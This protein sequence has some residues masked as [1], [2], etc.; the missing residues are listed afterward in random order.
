MV[1]VMIQNGGAERSMEYDTVSD[2]YADYVEAEV[3]PRAEKEANVKLARR[4]PKAGWLSA[5]VRRGRV[6]YNGLVQTRALPSRTDILGDIRR[7]AARTRRSSRGM[8]I[9]GTFHSR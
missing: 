5:E 9:S 3:L 1:A 6:L 4:T 2:K 8:G 7:S